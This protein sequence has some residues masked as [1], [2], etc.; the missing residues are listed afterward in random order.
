M[1]LLFDVT[2]AVSAWDVDVTES[3]LGDGRDGW[4]RASYDGETQTQTLAE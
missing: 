4:P 3:V 2:G 1:V